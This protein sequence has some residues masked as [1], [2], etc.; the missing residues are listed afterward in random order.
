MKFDSVMKLRDELEQVGRLR[1]IT[2]EEKGRC[3]QLQILHYYSSFSV[4]M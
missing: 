1:G 3:M 4:C 2:Q